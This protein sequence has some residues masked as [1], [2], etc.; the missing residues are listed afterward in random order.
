M[1]RPID[2]ERRYYMAGLSLDDLDILLPHHVR[3]W[4]E[5]EAPGV[6]EVFIQVTVKGLE[7]SGEGVIRG[8]NHKRGEVFVDFGFRQQY[9]AEPQEVTVHSIRYNEQTFDMPAVAI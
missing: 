2:A 6:N 3:E 9:W 8:L 1:R 4:M 5:R 7:A